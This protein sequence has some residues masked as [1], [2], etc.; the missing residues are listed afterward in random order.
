[1]CGDDVLCGAVAIAPT[2]LEQ[3]RSTPLVA[4]SVVPR[5]QFRQTKER[6]ELHRP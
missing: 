2:T 4:Q 5:D 1:M 3:Q 6:T